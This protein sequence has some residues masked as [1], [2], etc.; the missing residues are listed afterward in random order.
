VIMKCFRH[1]QNKSRRHLLTLIEA[2]LSLS[3][4]TLVTAAVIPAATSMLNA[5]KEARVQMELNAISA[6]LAEYARDVGYFPGVSPTTAQDGNHLVLA[7]DAPIPQGETP[8]WTEAH[9]LSLRQYLCF[10]GADAEPSWSGPY[11]NT[12][13]ND[14]P[15]G[16]AYVINISA[17]RGGAVFALS[18]GRNGQI[19]TPF[20]QLVSNA[21]V[22][23]D[24]YAVRLQ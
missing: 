1:K 9:R 20:E 12:S 5:A 18:A 17:A 23:G 7:T 24:D 6:G 3:A 4:A 11:L 21:A 19:D 22:G 10:Q 2:M 15:W 16:N 14:D 13:I 8:Q